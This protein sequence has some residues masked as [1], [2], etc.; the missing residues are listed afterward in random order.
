MYFIVKTQYI[1]N[2]NK[3]KYNIHNTLMLNMNYVIS[4]KKR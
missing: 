4:F 2:L 1:F 3:N